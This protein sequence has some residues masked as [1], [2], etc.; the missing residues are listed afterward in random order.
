[1]A[2]VLIG[3]ERV[4]LFFDTWPL[5]HDNKITAT[6]MSLQRLTCQNIITPRRN[7][8]ES[9]SKIERSNKTKNITVNLC[10]A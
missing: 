7:R 3:D 4:K 10:H 1:M 5:L 8:T 2:N 9:R 6:L